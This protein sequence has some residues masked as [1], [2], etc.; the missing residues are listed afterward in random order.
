MLHTSKVESKDEELGPKT[1][2][3]HHHHG[4]LTQRLPVSLTLVPQSLR[5]HGQL[6]VYSSPSNNA[7]TR[8]STL[9]LET[10]SGDR[11]QQD[12]R[13]PLQSHNWR[14]EALGVA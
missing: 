5:D 3:S 12:P 4:S 7:W 10:G 11:L 8:P 2:K 13:R 14:P 1:R 9:R 6:R